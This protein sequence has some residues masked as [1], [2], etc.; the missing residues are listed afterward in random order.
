MFLDRRETQGFLDLLDLAKDMAALDIE[1]EAV[2]EVIY[3][4]ESI[5]RLG[6]GW[7]AEEAM[8]IAVYCVF[9]YPQSYE[10]AVLA[11]VNHGGDSDSTGSVTGNI[12]GAFYGVKGISPHLLQGLELRELISHTAKR[13]KLHELV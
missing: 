12:M 10:K 4:P 5:E 7:V 9:R 1:R 8:A 13:M 3:D 6:G 11:A 2:E